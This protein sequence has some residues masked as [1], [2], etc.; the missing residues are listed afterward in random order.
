MKKNH[1]DQC[2]PHGQINFEKGLVELIRQQEYMNWYECP[3]NQFSSIE[4]A[5]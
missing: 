2:A 1:K 3:W 5:L 4:I